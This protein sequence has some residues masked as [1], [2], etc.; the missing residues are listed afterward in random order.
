MIGKEFPRIA[1]IE[2]KSSEDGKYVIA[3]VKN[4][5][6]GE[7]ASRGWRLPRLGSVEACVGRA[8]GLGYGRA[9]VLAPLEA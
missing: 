3:H 7:V 8:A 6:G 4:G 5:D 2:M 9:V 1:E